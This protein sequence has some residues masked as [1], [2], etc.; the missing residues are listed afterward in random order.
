M[1]T[2]Q[3]V[4]DHH[5]QAF[6]TKDVDGLLADYTDQSVVVTDQGVAPR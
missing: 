6:F 5:M 3:E 1:A 4:Y 2:T